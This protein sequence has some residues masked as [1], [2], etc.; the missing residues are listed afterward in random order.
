MV[1]YVLLFFFIP[2]S[3]RYP[4]RFEFVVRKGV[5]FF[6]MGSVYGITDTHLSNRVNNCPMVICESFHLVY[7]VSALVDRIVEH[8]RADT[9]VTRTFWGVPSAHVE[10][11]DTIQARLN[12]IEGIGRV[13][14]K[15]TKIGWGL[16]QH[17]S[18]IFTNVHVCTGP[19]QIYRT[20]GKR[21]HGTKRGPG[22]KGSTVPNEGAVLNSAR[23]QREHGTE[24][25]HGVK[26]HVHVST[27]TPLQAPLFPTRFPMRLWLV[28]P[29]SSNHPSAFFFIK[30][31][32]W[33]G[34]LIRTIL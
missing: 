11:I 15:R 18:D 20:S 8:V 34:D 28:L 23:Y 9:S 14:G 22:N 31:I 33:G 19:E 17:R 13:Q 2:S 12:G 5:E 6:W 7:V 30:G 1:K 27:S 3:F 10:R 25:R 32:I 29:C 24:R 16:D 26:R 21:E 4:P